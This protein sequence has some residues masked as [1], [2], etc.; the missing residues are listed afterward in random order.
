MATTPSSEALRLSLVLVTVGVVAAFVTGAAVNLVRFP[1]HDEFAYF[2]NA[3]YWSGLHPA[4]GLAFNG[5]S[6]SVAFTERPPLFWWLMTSLLSLGANPYAMLVVSPLFTSL[7]AVVVAL[8]AYELTGDIKSGFFGGTLAAVSG[9]GASVGAHIQSDAMGSFFAVLAMYSFY[10]YCFKKRRIFV[11][12]LGLS[13]GFGLVARDEDLI[14]LVLLIAF[15]ILFV[16]R[17]GA[18]R[19]FSYLFLIGVAFGVPVL[20][21][22]MVGTLQTISNLITPLVFSGWPFVLVAGAIATTAFFVFSRNKGEGRMPIVELAVAFFGFFIAMLPFFFD[23]YVL[24][25]V[26][27]YIA[28]K[29]VLARPISHLMMIPQ[30]GGV[31]ASLSESAKIL[32]WSRSVPALLSIPVIIAAALGIYYLARSNR[33]KFGFLFLWGLVSLGFVVAGTNLE[34]RFLL[35]AFAPLMIFAGIGLGYLWRKNY[36]VA[37]I[38]AGAAFV[39]ADLIPRTTISLSNLTVVAGLRNFSQNWLYTFLPTISLSIPKPLMSPQLLAEGFLSLPFAVTVIGIGAYLAVVRPVVA[40]PEV[41]P[42]SPITNKKKNEEVDAP[43]REETEPRFSEPG[44][45]EAR[46]EEE[47]EEKIIVTEGLPPLD[48]VAADVSSGTSHQPIEPTSRRLW[49]FEDR[50]ATEEGEFD[51][52]F[53]KDSG[54]EENNGEERQKEN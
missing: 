26:E 17:G 27:Y 40:T 54:I 8:F 30:T 31:G 18:K 14:T 51:W 39:L 53:E 10:E 5:E 6:Y 23:N 36:I 34:D 32:A 16:P 37:G 35:I 7:N 52:L 28:G 49:T 45:E 4:S 1:E 21:L 9:F 12:V 25:N 29:G 22:G 11:L 48:V 24:G 42:A 38:F 33:K 46:D 3:L 20:Y 47:G 50:D 13:I 19:K 15:W 2:G 41:I 43:K 44:P